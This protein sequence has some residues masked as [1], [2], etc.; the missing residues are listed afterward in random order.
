MSVY[1]KLIVGIFRSN[2][3][4]NKSLIIEILS[5][6]KQEELVDRKF[7]TTSTSVVFDLLEPGK[8]TVRAI[9][10][11][12]KNNKWDTGNY[13]NKQLAEEIIYHT[14]INNADLRANFFLVENFTIN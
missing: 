5:G 14:E 9:V 1:C 2:N 6:S 12:N 11:K 10:D 13:L 8:Y 4:N 7:I 3:T